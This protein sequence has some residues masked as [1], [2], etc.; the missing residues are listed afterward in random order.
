MRAGGRSCSDA[1]SCPVT[2]SPLSEIVTRG[3]GCGYGPGAAF[4]YRPSRHVSQRPENQPERRGKRAVE[5]QEGVGRK[6]GEES[7]RGRGFEAET[8]EEVG[9]QQPLDAE[10]GELQGVL[11]KVERRE[12]IRSEPR[13]A[14][15]QGIHQAPVGGRIRSKPH[16][17]LFDSSIEPRS[18]PVRE[19][20]GELHLGMEPFQAVVLQRERLE[21][22]GCDAKGMH[23]GT[24]VV[25]E[26]GEGEFFGPGP[27]ADGIALLEEGHREPG[28]RQGDR[29]SEPV[30]SRTYHYGIESLFYR[31]V[32][33][34][35][36]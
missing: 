24:D 7:L 23:G 16:G 8:S 14:A 30:R 3:H 6:A 10:K 20:M 22:G 9:R 34:D 4:G 11:R 35:R 27:A 32:I 2:I 31:H 18:S 19:W 1:I 17:G 15:D 36:P 26:A 12:E 5:W 28:S 13:P 25:Q 29:G 21:K 33:P